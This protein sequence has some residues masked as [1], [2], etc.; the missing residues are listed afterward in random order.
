M[1]F[2]L[3][4]KE[5]VDNKREDEEQ[6]F[7]ETKAHIYNAPR[8]IVIKKFIK[9]GDWYRYAPREPCLVVQKARD[10]IVWS[11]DQVSNHKE[12]HGILDAL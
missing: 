3:L 1:C 8:V 2:N 4:T 5:N 10:D 9:S 7:H 11:D 6:C 12:L